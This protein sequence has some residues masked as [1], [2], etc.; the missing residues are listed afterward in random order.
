LSSEQEQ[1]IQQN[2]KDI[3]EGYQAALKVW[4]AEQQASEAE[5][6]SASLANRRE[7]A[8]GE[9]RRRLISEEKQISTDTIESAAVQLEFSLKDFEQVCYLMNEFKSFEVCSNLKHKLMHD[10]MLIQKDTEVVLDE[11]TQAA[12]GPY[13]SRGSEELRELMKLEPGDHA[14]VK[15]MLRRQG[16][17]ERRRL[18]FKVMEI[19][20]RAKRVTNQ[21]ALEV[22]NF[23]PLNE[24]ASRSGAR[25]GH[26][27]SKSLK[28]N[29]IEIAIADFATNEDEAKL[30]QSTPVKPLPKAS[31][32]QDEAASQP[33]VGAEEQPNSHQLQ[34]SIGQDSSRP[35]KENTPNMPSSAHL[36]ELKEQIQDFRQRLDGKTAED[37]YI[38]VIK[39]QGLRSSKQLNLSSSKKEIEVQKSPSKELSV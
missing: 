17:V 27:K 7:L 37:Y 36:A 30:Q 39:Q 20:D 38:E 32:K 16:L 29:E 26:L 35:G 22:L 21:F 15:E 1:V 9:L 28:A 3:T 11:F 10:F 24:V 25:M 23:P 4:I 33:V 14:G 31:I 12:V 6:L 34:D 2:C 19:G 13:R 18:E 8:K 5:F